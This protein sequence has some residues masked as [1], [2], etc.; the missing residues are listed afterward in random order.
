[1]A[2][3]C[4]VANIRVIYIHHH[5]HH[6]HHHPPTPQI[7]SIFWSKKGRKDLETR[8]VERVSPIC[9]HLTWDTYRTTSLLFRANLDS[10]LKQTK[11]FCTAGCSEPIRRFIQRTSTEIKIL[12]K[13]LRPK[14][15]APVPA[16]L[17]KL[18]T[19]LSAEIVCI[20]KSQG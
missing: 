8:V 13:T 10:K 2:L 11:L 1:M 3:L 18:E 14:P 7:W 4:V 15:V 12:L 9:L 5:H 17:M 20:I 16:E 6:H 19:F